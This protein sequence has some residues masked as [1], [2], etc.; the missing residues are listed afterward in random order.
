MIKHP[1][2]QSASLV[3]REKATIRDAMSAMTK[4]RSPIVFVVDSS[5]RLLGVSADIDLRRAI[6]RGADLNS[7]LTK[8]LNRKPLTLPIGSTR[9]EISVLFRSQPKAAIP[10]IDENRRLRAIAELSDYQQ[11]L[12]RFSNRVVVMAGGTGRRLLPLTENT[13]NRPSWCNSC[14]GSNPP[15]G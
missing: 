10:L 9:E 4:S 7:P 11:I 13:P 12:E 2:A 6:L 3:L 14:K 5:G 15:S 8:A 1:S